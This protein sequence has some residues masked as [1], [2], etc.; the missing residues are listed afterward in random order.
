MAKGT[1]REA[2]K[3]KDGDAKGKEKGTE[4][5][6]SA[7][8]FEGYCSN[9]DCGKL[10]HWWTG[11]GGGGGAHCKSKDNRTARTEE[12]VRMSTQWTREKTGTSFNRAAASSAYGGSRILGALQSWKE[13]PRP[14][15]GTDRDDHGLGQDSIGML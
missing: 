10:G 4:K 2:K 3:I 14:A 7:V 12:S 13:S 6:D 11:R 1:T 9:P 5:Q 15:V 8:E